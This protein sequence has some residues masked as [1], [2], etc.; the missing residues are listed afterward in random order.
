MLDQLT[1]RCAFVALLMTLS[2]FYSS[3]LFLLILVAI[4]DIASHWLHLHATDLT[5]AQ[6]HKFST[7][8]ILNFYYTSKFVKISKI[9]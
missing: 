8:F 9:I 4:L 1:D 7:N 2:H 5:G 3:L 6:S